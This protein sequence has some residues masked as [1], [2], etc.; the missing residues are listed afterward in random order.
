MI[1]TFL[2]ALAALALL[3]P[4]AKADPGAEAF[5]NLADAI[6]KN[7][8]VGGFDDGYAIFGAMLTPGGKMTLPPR[9]IRRADD[10]LF[11]AGV[12][13]DSGKVSVT[14]ESG[15]GSES[16]E[17]FG[18]G[19][20]DPRNAQMLH[21][22]FKAKISSI[23][24]AVGP[25]GKPLSYKFSFENK[26]KIPVFVAFA[27]LRKAPPVPV[28]ARLLK[29][30]W[31]N[32]NKAMN[33][34]PQN[35]RPPMNAPFIYGIPLASGASWRL[36]PAGLV[37]KSTVWLASSSVVSSISM[38]L[39]PQANKPGFDAN[40]IKKP[41]VSVGGATAGSLTVK[42]DGPAAAIAFWTTAAQ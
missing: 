15:A 1:R 34:G 12:S 17:V 8:A 14:G 40:S 24:D 37:A 18:D 27:V 25:D 28:N 32:L 31:K 13:N 35:V 5:G 3:A 38:L 29:D 7:K 23:N 4:A 33:S 16:I 30:G 11:G 42:N 26:G 2:A 39:V 22:G 36:N 19:D 21:D 10:V 41:F 9:T 20:R 6:V